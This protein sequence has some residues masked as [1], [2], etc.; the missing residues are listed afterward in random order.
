M[1]VV[2]GIDLHKVVINP[3]TIPSRPHRKYLI[4]IIQYICLFV[5]FQIKEV[6]PQTSVSDE[7]REFWNNDIKVNNSCIQ[8]FIS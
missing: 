5:F 2:I 7:T 8:I 3:L 1:L 6:A 4:E